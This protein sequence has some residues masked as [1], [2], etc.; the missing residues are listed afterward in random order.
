MIAR[1]RHGGLRVDGRGCSRL[2]CRHNDGR[3][4][5]CHIHIVWVW[6]LRRHGQPLE[7]HHFFIVHAIGDAQP[8]AHRD[9][10]EQPEQIAQDGGTDLSTLV[11]IFIAVRRQMKHT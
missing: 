9:Q 6:R 3:C 4:G 11:R 5:L 1:W 2:P 8:D 7:F 10:Y